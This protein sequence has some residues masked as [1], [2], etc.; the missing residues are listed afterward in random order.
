M[1]AQIMLGLQLCRD[2]AY[3]V[4]YSTTHM[5]S[6]LTVNKVII[7]LCFAATGYYQGTHGRN[8]IKLI[9]DA[10]TSIPLKTTHSKFVGSP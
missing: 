2:N 6:Q 7:P 4:D 5:A 1:A 9:T 10:L 3:S 8:L